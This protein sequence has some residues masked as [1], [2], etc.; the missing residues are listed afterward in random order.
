MPS[1]VQQNKSPVEK[2]AGVRP[3]I[4]HFQVFGCSVNVL[5]P[6]EARHKLDPKSVLC[7]FIGYAEDQETRVY[8]LYH[9]E[10]GKTH[11]SR[12]VVFDQAHREHYDQTAWGNLEKDLGNTL[13]KVKSISTND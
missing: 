7:K 2:W 1:R 3:S 10:T 11:I 9:K 5:I 4:A 8:K 12:Y 13:L 6:A